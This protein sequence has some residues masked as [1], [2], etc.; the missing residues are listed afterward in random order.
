VIACLDELVT[1]QSADEAE[2]CSSDAW[3]WQE[4]VRELTRMAARSHAVTR[5]S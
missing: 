4:T 3:Q 1:W 5:S 2:W